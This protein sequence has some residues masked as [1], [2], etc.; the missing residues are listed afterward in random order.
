MKIDIL[1]YIN[2]KLI[3][4]CEGYDPISDHN[5]NLFSYKIGDRIKLL[6]PKGN[7]FEGEMKDIRFYTQKANNILA[8]ELYF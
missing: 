1:I 6:T 7:I 8:L 3:H 5:S 2:E 4:A